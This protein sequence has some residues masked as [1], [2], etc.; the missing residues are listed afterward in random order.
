MLLNLGRIEA[1]LLEP[2]V[3]GSL[4]TDGPGILGG[5]WDHCGQGGQP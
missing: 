2:K 3:H 1:N 5:K 4:P